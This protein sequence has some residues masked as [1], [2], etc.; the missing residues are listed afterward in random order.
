MS[1]EKMWHL[2]VPLG[3]CRHDQLVD[4]AGK[5]ES[6][7][8]VGV[9]A[10][11]VKTAGAYKQ[12]ALSAELLG[13]SFWIFSFISMICRYLCVVGWVLPIIVRGNNRQIY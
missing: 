7:I 8:I 11:E 6:A 2:S 9:L 1:I 12:N 5:H 10:N 13:E 3:V 4:S